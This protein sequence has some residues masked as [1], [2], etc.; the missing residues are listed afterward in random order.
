M[1]MEG[2]CCKE[3]REGGR[4]YVTNP[5]FLGREGWAS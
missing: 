5:G 2:G 4:V 3:Y 1:G